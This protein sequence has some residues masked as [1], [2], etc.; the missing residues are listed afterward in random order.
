MEA[1]MFKIIPRITI[2]HQGPPVGISHGQTTI[3]RILAD[4]LLCGAC[5]KNHDVFV[6][7]F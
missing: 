2:M 6:T 7:L 4:I 1:P 3:I 5:S